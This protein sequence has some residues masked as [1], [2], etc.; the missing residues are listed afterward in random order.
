MNSVR[1][2]SEPLQEVGNYFQKNRRKTLQLL[3]PHLKAHI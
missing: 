2:L 3:I 1:K